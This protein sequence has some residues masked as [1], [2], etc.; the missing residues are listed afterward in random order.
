MPYSEITES[1][2]FNELISS[3]GYSLIKFSAKWNG[4]LKK[5]SETFEA[6][7]D[8]DDYED[9]PLKF[10]SVCTDKVD[11]S[12]LY[13]QTLPVIVLYHEGEEIN[14]TLAGDYRSIINMLDKV[15]PIEDVKISKDDIDAISDNEYSK[16]E[17]GAPIY[18]LKQTPAKV[19]R[20][21]YSD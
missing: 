19:D 11:T 1:H 8:M 10:Y 18:S 14:R 20:G 6:I 7:S 3:K 17:K 12:K 15:F 4:S 13:L 16:E 2:E 5:L 9:K 21:Y